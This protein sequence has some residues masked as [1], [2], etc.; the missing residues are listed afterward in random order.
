MHLGVNN[1]NMDLPRFGVLTPSSPEYLLPSH[2]VSVHASTY[3]LP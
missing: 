1:L 2:W 3:L